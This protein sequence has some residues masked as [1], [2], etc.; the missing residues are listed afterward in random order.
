MLMSVRQPARLFLAPGSRHCW[1][2]L[3]LWI[4]TPGGGEEKEAEEDDENR[5]EEGKKTKDAMGDTHTA[6]VSVWVLGC[7]DN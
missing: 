4:L 5:E 2:R 1:S 7:K 3:H 6:H